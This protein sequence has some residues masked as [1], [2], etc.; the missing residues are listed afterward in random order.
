[1]LCRERGGTGKRTVSGAAW[2]EEETRSAENANVSAS[3]YDQS[4][5][6]Y[7]HRELKLELRVCSAEFV[8][9]SARPLCI[10]TISRA[11]DGSCGNNGGRSG[12]TKWDLLVVRDI[13]GTACAEPGTGRHGGTC[14]D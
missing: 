10:F 6:T 3:G 7:R 4:N 12:C 5:I 13:E 9:S 2:I 11:V 14:G 8:W 1:M